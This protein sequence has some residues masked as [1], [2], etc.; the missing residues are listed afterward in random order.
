MVFFFEF[1]PEGD[2]LTVNCPL[3]KFQFIK[4]LRKT[5][6]HIFKKHLILPLRGD[7]T[8]L[9]VNKDNHTISAQAEAYW[10]D[11]ATAFIILVAGAY[12]LYLCKVALSEKK[13]GDKHPHQLIRNPAAA[14]SVP[15]N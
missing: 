9:P 2:T 15:V 6:K 1:I 4:R 12:A 10:N 7:D 5:N 13:P 11:S 14:D 8:I 3:N